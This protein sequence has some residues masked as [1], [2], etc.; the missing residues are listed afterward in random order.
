MLT[1]VGS[2]QAGTGLIFILIL[3]LTW[4]YV[5]A[6]IVVTTQR[7]VLSICGFVEVFCGDSVLWRFST[8]PQKNVEVRQFRN[9]HKTL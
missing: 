5:A 1:S 8:N 9:V 4:Y 2:W 3:E 7:F 6:K